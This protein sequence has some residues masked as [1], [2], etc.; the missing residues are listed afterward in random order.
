MRTP[1]TRREARRGVLRALAALPL[2]WSGAAL[3]GGGCAQPPVRA[4]RLLRMAPSQQKFGLPDGGATEIWAFE[5]TAPGP[6]LRFRQGEIADMDV[7]NDLPEP[8]TVHWH[9][10]RVS[11]AMDG[12]PYM[13]Q[14][15]IAP[16]ENFR[17]RFAL[18]D[19]GTYWYHPHFRSF[20]QVT[21]GLYGALVVEE[22]QPPE[23]DEDWTWVLADWLLDREGVMR[24]DFED[25]RDMSHA[26]RIGNLVTLNGR[27]AMHRDADPEPLQLRAGTR[28][29]LRLLNAASA[30]IFALRFGGAA[31]LLVATDGHPLEPHRLGD[32]SLVLGP[33]M[34]ADLIIDVPEGRVTVSE[35]LDP[36]RAFV[37]R[38]LLGAGTAKSRA[39]F[40]PLPP[41]PLPEPDLARARRHE[42]VLEGGARGRLHSARVRGKDTPVEQLLRQHGMAWAMNGIAANDHVHEPLLTLARGESCVIALDNRTQWPH[43]MHLH[44]HAFRVLSVNG[45]PPPVRQWRDTVI[46]DPEG[47]AEI[48]F[49]ADNPGD[50]MFH[51]HILQHQQGG[52]M[53]SIRVN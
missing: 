43:P 24:N 30:R 39:P 48:A 1:D 34:R 44:G 9:G 18:P 41:N 10:L 37:V 22:T 19:A 28:V 6:L 4:A 12:V 38:E 3:V 20:E 53:A 46:L 50:W 52:M 49:V 42:V 7:R 29:R 23:V 25:P 5:G 2:A 47:S 40:A 33:G 8:T 13:T 15:P 35:R 26:G 11:N 21:R 45:R 16:G 17:Y 31:P 14:P 27:F 51:C 36:R 32:E